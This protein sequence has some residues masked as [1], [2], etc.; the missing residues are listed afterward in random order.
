MVQDFRKLEIWKKSIGF[1]VIMY[2][3]TAEY[4]PSEIYNL[5]S[6]IRRAS[7]SISTNIAEGCGKRTKK[8]FLRFLYQVLGS[9]KEVESLLILS[10]KLGYLSEPNY[11]ELKGELEHLCKMLFRFIE[12][13]K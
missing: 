1:A 5:T 13:I 4:P 6:Q 2:K 3:S 12:A 11:N 8:D 9:G 10:K 7:T